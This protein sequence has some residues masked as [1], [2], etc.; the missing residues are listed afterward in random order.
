[1]H[2]LDKVNFKNDL[3]DMV[4][5]LMLMAN[6]TQKQDLRFNNKKLWFFDGS[7]D[8]TFYPTNYSLIIC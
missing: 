6:V 1:M 3:S 2:P 8:S 7:I 4:D 5:P